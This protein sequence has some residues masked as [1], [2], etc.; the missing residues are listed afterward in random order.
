[1]KT[2]DIISIIL[3]TFLVMA[4]LIVATTLLCKS[5]FDPPVVGYTISEQEMAYKTEL[6]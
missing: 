4:A 2:N 1:M 6:L 5:M 3:A